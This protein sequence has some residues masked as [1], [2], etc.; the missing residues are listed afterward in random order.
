MPKDEERKELTQEEIDARDEKFRTFFTTS[1]A[2]VPQEMTRRD[3]EPTEKPK[4]LFG[5]LF[6][7][8][9]TEPQADGAAEESSTGEIRLGGEEPEEPSELELVL[10]LEEETEPSKPETPEPAG[11]ANAPQPEPEKPKR[12]SPKRR[13]RLP[14][15]RTK[16]QRKNSLPPGKR[17]SSTARA[18]RRSST[19][20]GRCRR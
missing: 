16:S 18:P 7:R 3:D 8:E 5:R 10:K 12:P 1:V 13:R 11:A 17:P 6:R 20:T 15:S 14:P 9:K 2:Q 4:G 19:K